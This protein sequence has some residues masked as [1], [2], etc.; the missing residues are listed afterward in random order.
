[1]CKDHQ[2]GDLVPDCDDC[3]SYYLCGNNSITLKKCGTGLV[4]D[5]V[6][7]AC[8]PGTCPRVDGECSNPGPDPDPTTT[9]DPGPEPCANT[10]VKCTFYGQM[11]P[12]AQ[13]CQRFWI[14]VGAGVGVCPAEGF[15]ELGQWF[16]REKFVCDFR[17]NVYNCPANVD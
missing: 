12:N 17:E 3:S 5:I 8:V 9:A 16:N 2:V 14:C 13:H 6:V 11:L 7:N 1:M 4:F 15:C 10:A